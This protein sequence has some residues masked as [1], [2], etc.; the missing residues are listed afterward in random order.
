MRICLLGDFKGNPDEGMKNVS[1]NIRE[2]LQVNHDVLALNSRDVFSKRFFNNIR[3]FQPQIIHYLHGPT[4]RSLIILKGAKILTGNRAKLICSAT[5]PYFSKLSRWAVPLVKPDL[6]L[7]QSTRFETLFREKNCRVKFIPNGVDCKKFRPVSEDE[8]L[9]IRKKLGLPSDER[10]ILHVGHIK[11]N[12][13]LDVFKE[14]QKIKNV[15][16]VIVGSITETADERLKKDLQKAGIK[17]FHKLYDDISQFYKMADLYIFPLS[18]AG[19]KLPV[20]YNQAGAID[21]PLSVLEA[22]ACNLPVVTTRF[23]A[24]ER[25]FD[26]G[27]GL[28]YVEDEG[29][30]IANV[31]N[32]SFKNV[33]EIRQ[34]VLPYDWDRIVARIELEY[35]DLIRKIH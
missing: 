14:I 20:S 17:V 2:Q 9:D 10:I 26:Q 33:C 24:L 11:T 19:N 30:I 34:K 13:N 29:D 15:Q 35:K 8:K 18:H 22:M 7:T 23:G 31:T 28:H 6:I 1:K 12:R 4:I 25:L 32:F 21:L 16:V 27:C 3:Y 5:R